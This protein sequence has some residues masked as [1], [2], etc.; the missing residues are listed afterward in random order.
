MVNQIDEEAYEAAKLFRKQRKLRQKQ[1]AEEEAGATFSTT[2]LQ[3]SELTGSGLK[4]RFAGEDVELSWI[5]G[6]ASTSLDFFCLTPDLFFSSQKTRRG[7]LVTKFKSV[8][9]VMTRG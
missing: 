8:S 7:T 1:N 6:I 5:T 9:R 4:Y 3:K 2:D